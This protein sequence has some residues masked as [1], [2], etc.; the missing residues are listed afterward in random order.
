MLLPK[1]AF[2]FPELNESSRIDMTE[3]KIRFKEMIL[4]EPSNFKYPRV[5]KGLP[6]RENPPILTLNS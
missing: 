6:Y 2:R 1:D 4:P 3:S 5:L